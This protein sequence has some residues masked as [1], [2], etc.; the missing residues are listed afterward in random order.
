LLKISNQDLVQPPLPGEFHGLS[1]DA[2][3]KSLFIPGKQGLRT[4]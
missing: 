4:L 2:L 1:F 3:A